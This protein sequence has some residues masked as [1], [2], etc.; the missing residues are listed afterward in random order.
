LV[1][2]DLE[3]SSFFALPVVFT[4]LIPDPASFTESINEAESFSPTFFFSSVV[5]SFSFLS[6]VFFDDSFLSLESFFS[7]ESFFSDD[8]FFSDF[9]DLSADLATS[10]FSSLSSSSSFYSFSFFSFLVNSLS[11]LS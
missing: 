2:S 4:L 3:S 9:S 11:F 8:S 5:G 7:F 10:P 6:F 1:S